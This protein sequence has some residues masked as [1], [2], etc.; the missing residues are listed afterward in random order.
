MGKPA[1]KN[2][3]CII[4]YKRVKFSQILI[5]AYLWNVLLAKTLCYIKRCVTLNVTLHVFSF[6]ST[7]FHDVYA[8]MIGYNF[9]DR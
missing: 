2:K 3:L 4:M 6:L 8:A 9:V 7:I 1:C 5:S